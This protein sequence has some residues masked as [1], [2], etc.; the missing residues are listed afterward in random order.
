[1]CRDDLEEKFH[2]L[3]IVKLLTLRAMRRRRSQNLGEKQNLKLSCSLFFS[4]LT[5]LQAGA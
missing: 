5:F 2:E 1:M 4:E 3:N